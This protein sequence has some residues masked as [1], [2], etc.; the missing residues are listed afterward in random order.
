MNM[1]V[2][3]R[4]G[5]MAAS[6]LLIT[7]IL[8]L[9]IGLICALM[10]LLAYSNLRL[11]T[12]MR[13]E[14]QLSRNLQSSINLVL[15]DTPP[16]GMVMQKTLDLFG[17]GHDSA[18]IREELWGVYD[19]ASIEVR[20]GGRAR[21]KLF[22]FGGQLPPALD[23]CLYLAEHQRSLYLVGSTL[24]NGKA[25]LPKGGVKPGYIDQRGYDN[26]TLVQGSVANSDSLPMLDPALMQ[27][28]AGLPAKDTPIRTTDQVPTEM[29]QSF[30]DTV[31]M[32]R[33]HGPVVLTG[34]SLSGHIE[35]V[36]DSLI[37]VDADA[38]LE[39]VVLTAPVI[40]FKAGFSGRIQARCSDSLV[41]EENCHFY[42][43]SSLMLIRKAGV[44]WQPRMIIAGNCLL[45]GLALSW[46]GSGD[47]SM[48]YTEVGTGT[49]IRGVLYTAGYLLLKG[50][51]YGATLTDYFIYRTSAIVYENYLTDAQLNRSLLSAH[52]AGPVVFNGRKNN[53]IGQWVN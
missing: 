7:V 29:E 38:R 15:E 45:E 13:I 53:R 8:S 37:E 36:S 39:N 44:T 50:N 34:V 47:K 20:E 4:S 31:R 17:N 12:D 27:Y 16:A 41:A 22:F 24:L 1:P 6:S 46:C 49:L 48:T 14:D 2:D 32:I 10:I 52:F 25:Y 28:Y 35:I 18:F 19:V 9:V 40:R 26:A 33:G 43:P 5:R 23:G 3:I 11:R 51:V 30:G 21:R 42:Y